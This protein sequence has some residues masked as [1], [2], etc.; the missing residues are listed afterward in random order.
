MSE[1]VLPFEAVTHRAVSGIE[2]DP[3]RSLF[4]GC[5]AL[6]ANPWP[7]D[8]EKELQAAR[9]AAI[10]GGAEQPEVVLCRCGHGL[11]DHRLYNTTQGLSRACVTCSCTSW[12][13]PKSAEQ[14]QDEPKCAYIMTHNGKPCE[15]TPDQHDGNVIRYHRFVPPLDEPREQ[16][17]DRKKNDPVTDKR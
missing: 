17:K 14:A 11:E 3:S 2:H 6:C 10:R 15:G 9:L 8:A 5:C 7:C 4:H 1:T 12:M 16:R 13:P